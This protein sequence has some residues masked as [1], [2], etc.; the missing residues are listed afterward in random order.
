MIALCANAMPHDIARGLT[1][2]FCRYLT[3]PIK[4]D[5]FM[6][7]LDAVLSTHGAA[8]PTSLPVNE[9]QPQK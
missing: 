7:T 6:N 1:A 5:E 3:R 9:R 2:G 8:P 4:V